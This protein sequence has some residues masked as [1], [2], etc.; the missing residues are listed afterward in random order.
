MLPGTQLQFP[1]MLLALLLPPCAA[2]V[3]LLTLATGKKLGLKGAGV[4]SS[5]VLGTSSLLLIRVL[6][7]AIETG[8]AVYEQYYWFSIGNI[9]IE[10]SLL[11]DFL[12]LPL[13]LAII[14]LTTVSSVYS[15]EYISHKHDF[16]LY[17]FLLLLF[18]TGMLGVTLATN[19][20]QFYV[21]FEGMNIPAYFLVSGWGTKKA[22]TI[23]MKYILYVVSGAL[24]LL[25]GIVWCYSLTN[26]FG[27]YDIPA[28]LP[29]Y[30]QNVNLIRTI[31]LIISTGFG[32]KMGMFP[33]HSWL[34]DFHG[35][36][37]VPIHALL[38][39][40]MIKTGAY[41]LVRITYFFFPQ[42]VL[43]ASF[44]LAVL[45]LITMWWGAGMALVQ[46]DFKR[47]LA[48]SSVNQ[49]GYILLGLSTGTTVGIAGGLFHMLTHGLAKGVLLYCAGSLVHS[50][51]TK[52]I[53]KLGGVARKMPITAT[54][55]LIGALAIAGTPPLATF[56]SEFLIF[57]GTFQAGFTII[58]VLGV[59][60]TALTA[61]YYLW[62]MKRMFFGPDSKE[63]DIMYDRYIKGIE[64][65]DEGIPRKFE[66]VHES[67]TLMIV[68]MLIIAISVVVLGIFPSF[69]LELIYPVS[70][71]LSNLI[72]GV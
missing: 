66:D 23:A 40:V 27:I 45:A 72:G 47:V 43:D 41:G 7:L 17:Y 22:K 32:I 10:F 60:S 37:P 69:V 24:C 9:T 51:G 48:Y 46:V 44:I 5:I 64:I 54:V 62:T 16:E 55:A 18:A 59:C 21:F 34:P 15:I 50:A 25:A 29:I 33:V 36:A 1:Y 14:L 31:A 13:S 11:S 4:F 3:I 52:Y 61:G 57:A 56:P 68:P 70:E 26:S 65:P 30:H 42:V 20:I 35:E 58:A 67:P 19:L 71:I 6:F 2:V 28:K 63:L 53:P 39:A 8:G 49:V 38:S 12:N